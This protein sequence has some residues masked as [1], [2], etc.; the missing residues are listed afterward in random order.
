MEDR[1]R[2]TSSFDIYHT[3]LERERREQLTNVWY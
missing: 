1:P 3:I 2:A